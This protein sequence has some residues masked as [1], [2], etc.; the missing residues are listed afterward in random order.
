M[1]KKIVGAVAVAL[2]ALLLIAGIV[3]ASAVSLVGVV[4]VLG[5]VQSYVRG[6]R[7]QT[8]APP[9]PAA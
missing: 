1:R 4:L 8:Q 6:Q 5:G 3:N 2:G 7:E 9:P